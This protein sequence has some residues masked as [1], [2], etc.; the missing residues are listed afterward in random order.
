MRAR[1]DYIF[2][3]C[4]PIDAVADT[5]IVSHYVD[6]SLFVVRAGRLERAMLADLEKLYKSGRLNDLAVILNGTRCAGTTYAYRYGYSYGY[7]TGKMK[8]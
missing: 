5:S 1:Y 2:I 8:K 7:G 6:R 3:D 4:P